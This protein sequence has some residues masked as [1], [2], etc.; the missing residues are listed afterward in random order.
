LKALSVDSLERQ[1]VEGNPV[2]K[3]HAKTL[4]IE[5][6]TKLAKNELV[7]GILEVGTDE[8]RDGLVMQ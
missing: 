7:V 8:V 2:E 6:S 1:V 5:L 4:D 3:Q